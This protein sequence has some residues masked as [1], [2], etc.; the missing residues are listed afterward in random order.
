[1]L[2][3]L[4][5]ALVRRKGVEKPEADAFVRSVFDII[6]EYLQADR[7]I[8]IKGLGTFKLVTVDSRESVDVNTGERIV[9][10]EYTK[11]NFT[12]D[13]VMRDA[14]NKP[15][16]QFETVVLYEG[17]DVE[18]M[19]R[20]DF[21]EEVPLSP[22]EGTEAAESEP[23][24][25]EALPADPLPAE[26]DE[27]AAV[28]GETD[29]LP[30]E[31]PVVEN[32]MTDD[33]DEGE[34]VAEEEVP[35]EIPVCGNPVE[36]VDDM[37]SSAEEDGAADADA[38]QTATGQPEESPA[39]DGGAEP[40]PAE[41]GVDTDMEPDCAGETGASPLPETDKA[42]G[43]GQYSS[44]PQ[45][46]QAVHVSSQHIEIQKVEHQN[47]EH[48]HIVQVT[49]EHGSRRIYLTPWMIFFIS[50]VVLLLMLFSYY[51]GYHRMFRGEDAGGVQTVLPVPQP[52][53]PQEQPERQVVADTIVSLPDTSHTVP[54]ADSLQEVRPAAQPP[55]AEVKKTPPATAYPQVENGAYEIVGTR[56]VHRMKSGETLRGVALH[57]YGS[58]SFTI[59]LVAYNKIA[60]P[61][62][63][64]EGMLLKIPELKLKRR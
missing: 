31:T 28:E 2:Q 19:E 26:E 57:Y 53:Q 46:P 23:A 47:V 45:Q 48:Q 13:P 29:G 25:A 12:P 8:K 18:E 9:I 16:A 21:P 1:M 55:K 33:T 20:L 42:A 4:A 14:V 54:A 6:A 40:Q 64:P 63:V 35:A 32:G 51:L 58:K 60:N 37:E 22:D 43:G 52:E 61:D 24:L 36:S 49:P 34:N 41:P 3:D 10:K 59:Y 39:D 17:T 62:V 7:I 11:V 5:D 56:E 44:V 30:A 15:F 50:L 38:V 27:D